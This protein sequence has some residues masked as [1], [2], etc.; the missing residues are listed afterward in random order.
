MS[1][2]STMIFILEKVFNYQKINNSKKLGVISKTLN[3]K[4]MTLIE[5]YG[6]FDVS[7]SQYQDGL[8][9][10]IIREYSLD[11]KSKDY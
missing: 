8:I 7:L 3:P 5:L 1:G 6:N 9:S 10:K 11:I 4:S 2:K